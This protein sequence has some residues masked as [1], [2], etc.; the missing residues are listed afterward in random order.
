[1]Y[2]NDYAKKGNKKEEILKDK[3]K[4][5]PADAF[6]INDDDLMATFK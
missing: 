6:D 3:P 2:S 4:A 5:K 1:M